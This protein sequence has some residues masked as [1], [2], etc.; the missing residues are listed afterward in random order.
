MFEDDL[1][2]ELIHHNKQNNQ[3]ELQ[4]LK[5]QL[6]KLKKIHAKTGIF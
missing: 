2:R 5:E 4:S 1:D 3:E 6:E